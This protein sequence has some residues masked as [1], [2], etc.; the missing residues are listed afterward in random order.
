[1]LDDE[2]YQTVFVLKGEMSSKPGQPCSRRNQSVFDCEGKLAYMVH[3]R[4]LVSAATAS[5]MRWLRQAA[6]VEKAP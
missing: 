6:Q 1:M 5:G 4:M 2:Q 3:V